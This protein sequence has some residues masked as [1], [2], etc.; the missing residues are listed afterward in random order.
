MA[1][2]ASHAYTAQAPGCSARALSGVGLA[3]C[4]LPRSEQLRRP[5]DLWVH[6]LGGLSI[7]IISLVP[8]AWFSRCAV[9]AP[10]QVCHLSPLGS[11]SQAATL[12]VDVN[13]SRSQEDMVSSWEPAHSLVEDAISGAKIGAAPCLRLWLSH[14]CLSTLVWGW[15]VREGA[16]TQPASSPLV[17]AQSFV[18]WAGQ[19]VH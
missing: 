14:T 16:S 15:G 11:W 13:H 3:F 10:S 17:F 9:R 1:V 5:G 2:H 4:A 7:L 18:P 12:L 6:F 8:A 19:A